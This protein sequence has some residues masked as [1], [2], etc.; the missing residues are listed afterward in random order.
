YQWD[1]S[2]STPAAVVASK[3]AVSPMTGSNALAAVNATSHMKLGPDGMVYFCYSLGN[4]VP[5]FLHRIE[6]PNLRGSACNVVFNAIPLTAG[7][8]ASL[9]LS[10]DVAVVVPG[11]TIF[12]THDTLVCSTNPSTPLLELKAPSGGGSIEWDDGSTDSVRS[13]Q[14]TGVFW[15]RSTISC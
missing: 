2:L 5:S 4:N 6:S 13:V 11:D 1:L 9:G 3:M 15:V 12:S 10:G 7:S 14:Q 8:R